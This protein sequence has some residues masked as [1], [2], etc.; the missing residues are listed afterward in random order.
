MEIARAATKPDPRELD[1]PTRELVSNL[2]QFEPE[3][4]ESAF[5]LTRSG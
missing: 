3:T 4:D 2:E 1:V 5:V